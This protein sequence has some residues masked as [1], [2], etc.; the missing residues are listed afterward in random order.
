MSRTKHNASESFLTNLIMKCYIASEE[1]PKMS[2][3]SLKFKLRQLEAFQAVAQ[4]GSVTRAAKSLGISQPATSRLLSDFSNS[5]AIELFRREAGTLI[6]TSEARYLLSEVGRVF[7]SLRHLEE[8]NRDLTDRKAGHLRIACLPGFASSH[9]PQLLASFLRERPGVN[10]TLEPDRPERILEWIIGEQYDCGITDGFSGHPAVEHTDIA[11]KTVC[12]FP[13]GHRLAELDRV[14]PLDLVD[15]KIIHTRKGSPFFTSLS[16][17]FSDY[18]VLLNSWVEVRQFST[19]CIMV[20]QGQGVSVVS[21][22]DAE[23]FKSLGMEIRPFDPEIVHWL[24][25][26]RPVS[27]SRSLLSLDFVETF[28]ESLQPYVIK[29]PP[30]AM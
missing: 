15:E 20:A 3:K 26:L 2:A 4:T 8:L 24:S 7:D 14:S 27:G 1:I 13:Q 6:P 28:V 11:V 10:L 12:I 23:Q 19:A 21:A 25:I 29:V 9:L 5:V 17:S 30:R 16:Q 18:G 22:I